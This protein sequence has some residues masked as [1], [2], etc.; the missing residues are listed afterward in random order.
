MLQCAAVHGSVIFAALHCSNPLLHK[1]NAWQTAG[2]AGFGGKP[3]E[4]SV[5]QQGI[6]W[7]RNAIRLFFMPFFAP[8]AVDNSGTNDPHLPTTV[9]VDPVL[10]HKI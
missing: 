9:C 3:G 10:E 4:L 5:Q 2:S 8:A 1:R 7:R 6:C